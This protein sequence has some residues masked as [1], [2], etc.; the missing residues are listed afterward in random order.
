MMPRKKERLRSNNNDTKRHLAYVNFQN[1]VCS[2]EKLGK[3]HRIATPSC[4]GAK[5]GNKWPEESKCWIPA[6]NGYNRG[7]V[8]VANN[9]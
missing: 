4:V 2:G 6:G 1:W 5:I 9:N 8:I 3:G 7:F